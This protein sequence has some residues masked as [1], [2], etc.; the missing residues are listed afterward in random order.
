MYI[1]LCILMLFLLLRVFVSLKLLP[2]V[3]NFI[4]V[5]IT[6]STSFHAQKRRKEK[7]PKREKAN[8]ARKG[9]GELGRGRQA[10]RQLGQVAQGLPLPGLQR[11]HRLA[12]PSD[13]SPKPAPY[14]STRVPT[15]N[16]T[17]DPVT[18]ERARASG[19]VESRVAWPRPH[20]PDVL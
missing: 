4:K 3:K 19:G 12:L 18:S 16:V 7:E 10:W 5:W 14:P 8:N 2:K 1:Y 13:P 20:H 17:P 6:S 9:R 11:C 15:G